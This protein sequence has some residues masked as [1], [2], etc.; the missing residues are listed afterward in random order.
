MIL[1]VEGND[2]FQQKL[3]QVW[4]GTNNILILGDFNS[5]L[6]FS[7]KTQNEKYLEKRVLG[8]LNKRSMK[9]FITEPTRDIKIHH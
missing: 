3:G 4:L 2:Y 6:Q 5:D 1:K 8:I 7:G 9:N